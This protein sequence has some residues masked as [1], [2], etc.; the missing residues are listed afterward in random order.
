MAIHFFFQAPVTQLRKRTELKAFIKTIFKDNKRAIGNI[1][2][3]FCCDEDLLA[4]NREH[5][6]HDYYTDIITFDLSETPQKT[7][8][9]IYISYERVRDNAAQLK[10]SIKSELHRV[11]FH[12]CLHLCGFKDKTPADEQQMR[13]EED[14][15]LK[16]YFG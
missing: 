14:K 15:Y 2:F 13:S 16:K 3:I 4:I 9:D 8:A 7:D 12:G 1:N 6:Q 11:I 5:L 10:K